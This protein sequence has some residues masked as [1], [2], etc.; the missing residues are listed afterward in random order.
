MIKLHD[1][2]EIDSA[3]IIRAIFREEGSNSGMGFAGGPQDKLPHDELVIELKDPDFKGHPITGKHAREDKVALESAG[4]RVDRRP[5]K[6][7]E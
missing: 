5:R 3:R 7:S 1:G 4:V 2:I 6:R